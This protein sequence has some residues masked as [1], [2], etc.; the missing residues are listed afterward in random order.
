MV[1][2]NVLPKSSRQCPSDMVLTCGQTSGCYLMYRCK[3][4]RKSEVLQK[5][6]EILVED[7]GFN[8]VIH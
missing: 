5:G 6:S 8:K 1:S 3:H 2:G 7:Y 4:C